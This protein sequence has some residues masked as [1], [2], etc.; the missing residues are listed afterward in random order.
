MSDYLKNFIKTVIDS[1]ES[2]NWE[3]SVKEWE[4]VDF[5]E[6]KDLSSSC[7]CG[8][9]G[10]R[11]LYTI[12][13]LVNGNVLAPIGSSCIKKFGREDMSEYVDN[14]MSMYK[15]MNAVEEGKYISLDKEYFSRKFLKF[16]YD[17]GVFL[18]NKY[19]GYDGYN[20][21]SFMLDMF[22]KNN[23]GSITNNQKSKIRAIIMNDIR[24]YLIDKLRHKKV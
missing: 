10:L 12:E 2:N 16:L 8:K 21:Y 17:E 19:N 6:D 15:L 24:R 5:D 1:S 11:Y 22:N 14:N 3:E 20:D 23:K 4:I 13:N 9:A 7:I 18:D